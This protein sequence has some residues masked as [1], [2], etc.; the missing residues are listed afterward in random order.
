MSERLTCEE[1]HQ[2]R[3]VQPKEVLWDWMNDRNELLEEIEK[4]N[5]IIKAQD[6]LVGQE[7]P[8]AADF[9]GEGVA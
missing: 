6:D 2:Q 8:E 1:W 9:F 5:R 3:I 7:Q 4:L